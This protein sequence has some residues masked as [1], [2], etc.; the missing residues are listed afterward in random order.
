MVFGMRKITVNPIGYTG[1]TLDYLALGDSISS[2]EGDIAT[3]IVPQG[4]A[5]CNDSG[6]MANEGYVCKWDTH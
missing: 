4:S 2:G 3:T 5:S 6:E 1:P